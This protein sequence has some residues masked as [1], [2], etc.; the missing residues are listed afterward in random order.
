MSEPKI[1]VL[2]K[3]SLVDYPATLACTIFLKGCNLRCPYCYNGPLVKSSIS[4]EELVS[5]QELKNHLIKRKN[6][7]QGL[8]V[9]GGEALLHKDTKEI[10]KFAKPLGYKV[11]LDT[12]GT[13]S[14]LLRELVLNPETKPDF[15]AM[16]IKTSPSKYHQLLNSSNLNDNADYI[17]EIKSSIEILS[18]YPR[19]NYEFRTVLVPELITKTEIAEIAQL[20]PHDSVW[21]LANFINK[22]CLEPLYN[23]LTPYTEDESREL[24]KLAKS[25]I[26]DTKIR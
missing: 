6:V 2:V 15:I 10:I 23:S 25:V 4:D 24:E 3:T 11:K 13:N 1:G 16:D 22:N 14:L 17:N 26:P 7:L 21:R 12:N 18:S 9:S 20:L 8:V 19:E 5:L